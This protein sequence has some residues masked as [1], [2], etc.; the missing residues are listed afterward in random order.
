ER[1]AI[2]AAFPILTY[3]PDLFDEISL[4]TG[5]KLKVDFLSG[6]VTNISKNKSGNIEPFSEVQAEIFKRGGLLG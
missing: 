2:N 4:L 6:K 3:H 1:N 5:D